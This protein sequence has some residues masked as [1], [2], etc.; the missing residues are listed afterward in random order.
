MEA[1]VS[2]ESELTFPEIT[3]AAED[4]NINMRDITKGCKRCNG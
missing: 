4:L 3:R 1:T 2:E